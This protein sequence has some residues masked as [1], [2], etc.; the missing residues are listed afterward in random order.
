MPLSRTIQ[1]SRTCPA[2]TG[3]A[4]SSN[5]TAPWSVNFT[6]LS[7]RFSSAARS[8]I[9]SPTRRSGTV[10]AIVIV[11]RKPLVSAR[12]VNAASSAATSPRG[13]NTSRCNVS[14]PAPALAAS[15]TKVVSA[16]R[17]SA[18]VLMSEAQRRSRS[19]RLERASNS[20][21]ASTPVS[22]V[23][24]SW[25]KTGNAPAS[26]RG[27]L[28]SAGCTRRRNGLRRCFVLSRAI[29]SPSA[30]DTACHGKAWCKNN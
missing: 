25:A 22:A 9:G 2:F 14:E 10:S 8:R 4:R 24:T 3:S 20:P 19:P 18:L 6:A 11:A 26:L 12:T 5:S 1:A 7:R 13:R 27:D 21:S 29:P 17:Y 28:L 23:R 15:M 30:P 16:A